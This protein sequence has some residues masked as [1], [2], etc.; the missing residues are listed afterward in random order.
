MPDR[1]DVAK[2]DRGNVK[3]D[4]DGQILRNTRV[5]HKFLRKKVR[6]TEMRRR[7]SQSERTST[8]EVH[9]RWLICACN[10]QCLGRRDSC[11]VGFAGQV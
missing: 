1:P 8:T 4:G 9:V 10:F 7:Q 11:R 3:S 5:R 2:Q 6:L